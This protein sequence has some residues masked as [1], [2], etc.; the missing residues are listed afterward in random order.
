MEGIA[1]R[2][3]DVGGW[4]PELRGAGVGLQDQM[5][6]ANHCGG[7]IRWTRRVCRCKDAWG[8]W[9]FNY[10]PRPSKSQNMLI[11]CGLYYFIVVCTTLPLEGLGP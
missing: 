3:G 9:D 10:D 7:R 1:W 4:A 5:D 6:S 11:D 2:L 8:K